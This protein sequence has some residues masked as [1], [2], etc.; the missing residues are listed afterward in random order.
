MN[1]SRHLGEVLENKLHYK[2]EMTHK[3]SHYK[4]SFY[5]SYGTLK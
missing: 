1:L 5:E 3:D 4:I 2:K